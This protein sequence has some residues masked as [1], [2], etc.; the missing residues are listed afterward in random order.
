MASQSFLFEPVSRDWGSQGLPV[1]EAR[2][3]GALPLPAFLERLGIALYDV[4]PEQLS[5]LLAAR[6]SY[7]KLRSF[8]S[9]YADEADPIRDESH[10]RKLDEETFESLTF[11][12]I[13]TE[14]PTSDVQ[15]RAAH[16]PEDI[17]HLVQEEWGY[18]LND[19]KDFL[20]RFARG[21]LLVEEHLREVQEYRHEPQYHHTLEKGK[22]QQRD[23]HA[24]V[25][26]DVSGTMGNRDRR[27]VVSR[28]LTLGVLLQGVEHGSH[29]NFRT[30]TDQLGEQV[31]GFGEETLSQLTHRLLKL[32][33]GG[34]TSITKC[35]LAA[36]EDINK[37]GKSAGADLVFITDGISR[38]PEESPLKGERLHVFVIG[39]VVDNSHPGEKNNILHELEKLRT[40]ATSPRFQS[41]SRE[42]LSEML[43]PSADDILHFYGMLD[44]IREEKSSVLFEE[45]VERMRQVLTNLEYLIGEY[46]KG[47]EASPESF[48]VFREEIADLQHDL[49]SASQRD[50]MKQN[51]ERLGE[52]EFERRQERK[53]LR[54]QEYEEQELSLNLSAGGGKVAR[55]SWKP[56]LYEFMRLLS[57]KV[58]RQAKTFALVLKEKLS[59]KEKR[60]VRRERWRL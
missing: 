35:L 15:R 18:Y 9:S 16:S 60:G 24:Y 56:A 45:E 57:K 33:V 48:A 4:T 54:E 19:P 34:P 21:E 51:A 14:A 43:V 3:F 39:N 12:M 46:E 7:K 44:Q 22:E 42:T 40:W 47:D 17:E 28:G 26:L 13:P 8:Q 53:R 30:F 49:N 1:N 36:L 52:G 23:K 58:V 29:L 25:L 32:Q 20:D 27:G 11:R 55:R 41:I 6:K 2:S 37:E 10:V 50:F 31:S 38:L 59:H 5:V